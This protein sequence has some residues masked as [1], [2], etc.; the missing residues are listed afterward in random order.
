MN[1]VDLLVE[2]A[3]DRLQQL[4]NQAAADGGAKA[5]LAQELA[6]DAAFLRKLKP[7]LILA[8]ARGEA[9]TDQKPGRGVAAPS[10]PQLPRRKP[11]GGPN[12][13]VVLGAAFVA[14]IFVAKVLD[15]RGRAHPRD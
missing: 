12:P 1:R 3:A 8:R 10:G 15:W 2:K 11:G 13:F 4:A 7:S 14:G 9:P 5:K 6:D